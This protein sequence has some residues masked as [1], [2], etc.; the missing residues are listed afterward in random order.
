MFVCWTLWI[1]F[2]CTSRIFVRCLPVLLK[3]SESSTSSC[4]KT[5]PAFF[6]FDLH[7]GNLFTF[8]LIFSPNSVTSYLIFHFFLPSGF[9]S[10][11][12]CPLWIIIPIS[13]EFFNSSSTDKGPD[14]LEKFQT[15]FFKQALSM[16]PGT[17]PSESCLFTRNLQESFR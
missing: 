4:Y 1:I 16:L 17:F 13:L 14:D 10:E 3:A 15:A 2:G 5:R 12:Y 8:L 9:R 6:N 7:R 11:L